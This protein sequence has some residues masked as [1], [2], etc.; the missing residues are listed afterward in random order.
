MNIC[1][2]EVKTK[3]TMKNA[4]FSIVVKVFK[5]LNNFFAAKLLLKILSNQTIMLKIIVLIFLITGLLLGFYV[6]KG[7]YIAVPVLDISTSIHASRCS[8][9]FFF[10]SFSIYFVNG[11]FDPIFL[12]ILENLVDIALG[13]LSN[14]TATSI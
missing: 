12:E 9:L 10:L 7:I 14:R 2:E 13:V 8:I 11:S 3:A 1:I 5:S 4:L 6:L